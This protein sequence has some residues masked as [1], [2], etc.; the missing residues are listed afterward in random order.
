MTSDSDATSRAR[1]PSIDL[2]IVSRWI[3]VEEN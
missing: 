3:I 1:A 2:T